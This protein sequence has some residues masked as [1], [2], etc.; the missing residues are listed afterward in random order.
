MSTFTLLV[1]DK[2]GEL[3]EKKV[4]GLD[5]L[6]SVCNYRSEDGFEEL[7]TWN[8]LNSTFLLY[9]KRKGK[10]N[11]ENKCV[12]PQPIHQE[13]FFGNL[14]LVKK[15][16]DHPQSITLDEWKTFIAFTKEDPKTECKELKK[17]DYEPEP[18]K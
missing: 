17:E 6:F 5:R 14:C 8:H 13:L 3:F 16:G 2:S 18:L 15:V 12:L 7:H 11:Y 1:L 4:K 10:N 9:G